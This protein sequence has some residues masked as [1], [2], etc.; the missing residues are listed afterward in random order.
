MSLIDDA[1]AIYRYP[2]DRKIEGGV[3]VEIFKE[4][5]QDLDGGKPIVATADLF[6]EIS[7]AGLLEIWNEFVS[8][9]K[10]IMPT[11]PEADRLF[12]TTMNEKKLLVIEDGVA[13]TLM[14]PEGY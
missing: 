1:D 13:F 14:Y 6:N 8:W 12:H 9:R 10:S 7:L 11:V 4:C 3:I 5:W 2:L